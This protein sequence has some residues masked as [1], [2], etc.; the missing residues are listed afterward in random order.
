MQVKRAE[1]TERCDTE[2]TLR[3]SVRRL[4]FLKDLQI[5][6]VFIKTVSTTTFEDKEKHGLGGRE[7]VLQ[8]RGWQVQRMIFGWR[9]GSYKWGSDVWIK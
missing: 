8:W 7:G 2:R 4:S 3:K 9:S 1:Q 5:T 6:T